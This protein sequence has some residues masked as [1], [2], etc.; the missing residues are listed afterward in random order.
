M[1]EASQVLV[2]KSVT[3][4]DKIGNFIHY[5]NCLNGKFMGVNVQSERSNSCKL[6]CFLPVAASPVCQKY[7]RDR[8]DKMY[9]MVSIVSSGFTSVENLQMPRYLSTTAPW[10]WTAFCRAFA[11]HF[12]NGLN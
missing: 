7:Q 4:D 10:L 9:F 11:L 5:A 2:L 8:F 12:T 3:L 1:K 6:S